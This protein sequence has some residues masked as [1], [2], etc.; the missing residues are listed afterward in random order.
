M[1]PHINVQSSDWNQFNV[2]ASERHGRTRG[3]GSSRD[4]EQA[5][6]GPNDVT[7][8]TWTELKNGIDGGPANPELLKPS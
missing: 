8:D 2:S 3:E 5:H 1:S 7:N 6:E 4:R